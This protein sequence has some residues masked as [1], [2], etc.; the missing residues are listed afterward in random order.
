MRKALLAGRI[1]IGIVFLYAAY[2]KLR[3]PW[4]LFALS[5]DSYRLLPEWAALTLARTLPWL[6][7]LLGIALIAG[8]RLRITASVSTILL[9]GFLAVMIRS[10]VK[11]LGIDC[12]CFGFGEALSG[13]TLARDSLLFACSLALVIGSTG[14]LCRRS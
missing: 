9:G 8:F 10:Y 6:E 7:L 3:Q 4:L 12:G 2:T 13:M 14:G 11:G 1:L 5:I